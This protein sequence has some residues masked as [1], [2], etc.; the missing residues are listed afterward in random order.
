MKTASAPPKRP[1]YKTAP[2][3]QASTVHGRGRVVPFVRHFA[4]LPG[5]G[6]LSGVATRPAH[7]VHLHALRRRPQRLPLHGMSI[8]VINAYIKPTWY[9]S[10]DG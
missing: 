10:L 3:S 4:V 8:N 6:Q 5:H 9:A 7:A 1:A 2:W